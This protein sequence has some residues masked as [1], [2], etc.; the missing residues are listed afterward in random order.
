MRTRQ[1]VSAAF[2]VAV[3]MLGWA[4]AMGVG[5]SAFTPLTPLMQEHAFLTMALGGWLAGHRI[6]P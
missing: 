6:A 5:R 3:G 2:P 4:A 1:M